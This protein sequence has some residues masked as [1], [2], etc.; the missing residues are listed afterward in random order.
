[1][2]SID[3][4]LSSK[5]TSSRQWALHW[6]LFARSLL[7]GSYYPA[8]NVE[9]ISGDGLSPAGVVS[10]TLVQASS[11]A[12]SVA[13]Y[14]NPSRWQTRSEAVGI[15][16]NCLSSLLQMSGG[17]TANSPFFNI[18]EAQ[19][20]CNQECRNWNSS[21]LGASVS[22]S[23]FPALHLEEIVTVA[24]T[25][26]VASI[27]QS[28]L[29]T[30]QFG[31]IHLLATVIRCFADSVDHELR[32]G[33]S[34]GG[35]ISVLEQYKSQIFS[36]I[37]H[38][39]TFV[40][41]AQL[42][43]SHLLFLFGCETFL[44]ALKK[45]LI[46]DGGVLKRQLS[47]I[48]PS[49]SEL[50]TSRFPMDKEETNFFRVQGQSVP[51][52]FHTLYINRL[53]KLVTLANLRRCIELKMVSESL[54][55][56][57]QKELKKKE[58]EIAIHSA[59]FALDGIRLLPTR[60]R[61]LSEENDEAQ[62]TMGLTFSDIDEIDEDAKS[63][64]TNTWHILATSAITVLIHESNDAAIE[65]QQLEYL[66]WWI[67]ALIPSLV[68]GLHGSVTKDEEE[69][70]SVHKDDTALSCILG[71]RQ[72]VKPANKT[73]APFIQPELVPMLEA[74]SEYILFEAI[75]LGSN[76]K[77]SRW[78]VQLVE[79]SCL[80]LKDV[81][82]LQ[83]SNK[84]L[85]PV[86]LKSVL[87]PL[88][89]LQDMQISAKT[90]ECKTVIT[91]CLECLEVLIVSNSES[92][93]FIK[94]IM[95]LCMDLLASTEEIEGITESTMKLLLICASNSGVSKTEKKA[96]VTEIAK[97]GNWAT[98]GA[99]CCR[100]DLESGFI[101]SL[102][103]LK[104]AL[105]NINEPKNGLDALRAV[106]QVM[107]NSANEA[108][109]IYHSIG[110]EVLLLLKMYGCCVHVVPKNKEEVDLRIATCADSMKITMA[111]LQCLIPTATESPEKATAFLTVAFE[112][113]ISLIQYNGLPN[114]DR[115]P[116]NAA[117]PALGKIAAQAVTHVVRSA[118]LVFKATMVGLSAENRSILETA[119]RADMT[120]Y[121]DSR[122]NAPTK[123][124]LSL[125]GF[126]KAG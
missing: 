88:A 34:V 109:L 9:G 83:S 73:V 5:I 19:K 16:N 49:E 1:M 33:A 59:A 92:A 103:E 98:W 71:I 23:S 115:S 114:A 87:T 86:L 52:S 85:K 102:S 111:A 8:R 21:A 125:K 12:L 24:C 94:A 107:Q 101:T 80:L 39:L 76:G 62:T 89:A 77:D 31:A 119:V 40:Q 3:R 41:Y 99:L 22:P 121:A 123:K 47:L 45:K 43:V 2:D 48:M 93:I 55:L 35:G 90:Q 69:K 6:L 42:N 57:V 70:S 122:T 100:L 27:E 105:R 61:R 51:V 81:V 50:K 116:H 75:G 53:S 13:E 97:N 91:A 10:S 106:S 112:V 18:E 26:S 58:V 29:V 78:G 67:E 25:S 74:V 96:L 68:V 108:G 65:Q 46:T 30:L 54:I 64:L 66:M 36:S 4:L 126:K 110:A 60:G 14:G 28:E 56:D 17:D 72:L 15:A 117:D 118:P 37:R 113:L 44:L 104:D 11:D 79:Q 20:F 32:T 82:S 63:V 84:G 38:A 124:K 95:K 120:G 7:T